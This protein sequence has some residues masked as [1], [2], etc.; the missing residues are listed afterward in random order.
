ME[1]TVRGAVRGFAGGLGFR[2][3]RAAGQTY[4]EGPEDSARAAT[5]PAARCLH[6]GRPSVFIP[7]GLSGREAGALRL[8]PRA[9]PRETL[10]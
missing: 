4:S 10:C 9:S 3:P 2:A 5:A 6:S 1:A 8:L 7:A